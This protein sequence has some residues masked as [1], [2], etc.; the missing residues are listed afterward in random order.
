MG[1]VYCENDP[2]VQCHRGSCVF[3]VQIHG[4]IRLP[5]QISATLRQGLLIREVVIAMISHRP[6]SFVQRLIM[7]KSK[8]GPVTARI[9]E[10]AARK[11]D[12]NRLIYRVG[13]GVS[14]R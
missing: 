4:F 12:W 11:N 13:T 7:M 5:N 9:Y 1:S 14:P 6:Q 2:T 8:N 10:V 3:P